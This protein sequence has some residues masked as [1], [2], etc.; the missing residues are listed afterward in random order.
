[1][2]STSKSFHHG[3]TEGTE[4]LVVNTCPVHF[5]NESKIHAQSDWLDSRLLDSGQTNAQ[6]GA[7]KAVGTG[8][9]REGPAEPAVILARNGGPFAVEIA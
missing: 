6:N 9:P 7:P 1:M 2:N 4:F 3:S 8:T 5:V